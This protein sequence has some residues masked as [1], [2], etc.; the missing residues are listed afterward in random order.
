MTSKTQVLL[1]ALVRLSWPATASFGAD[2]EVEL[3]SGVVV[4]LESGGVRTFKGIPFAKPPVGDLRWRPPQEVDPW[5]PQKLS[6]RNFRHNCLQSSYTSYLRLPR[7]LSTLSEDCLYLNVYAPAVTGSGGGKTPVMFWLSGGGFMG[8]GGNE[9]RL[10]GTWDVA[11]SN[12]GLCVVTSNYRLG[13]FG[14][15]AAN[16]LRERDPDNG[17]GNYGI[18][19]QR[20]A[21][22]W[23]QEN[24]KHFGCDSERVFLVGQSAGALSVSQHL[25]RPKSWGLFA[26]AGM[27]SG[28]FYNGRDEPNV[29]RKRHTYTSLA[30]KVNC[31]P[32]DVDCL[33]GTPALALLQA[34]IDVDD[35]EPVVD[36]TDLTKPGVLLAMDGKLAPVPVLVG[37]VS[38]DGMPTGVQYPWCT[39]EECTE[40]DFKLWAA[41]F[42]DLD[43]VD[44][45]NLTAAYSEEVAFGNYTKW[46]WAAQHAG[47]DQW[48]NCFARRTASWVMQSGRNAYFYRWSYAPQRPNGEFPKLADH[49]CEVPFVFHVLSETPQQAAESGGVYHITSS[50]V[51]LSSAVVRYWRGMAAEGKPEGDVKWPAFN[52]HDRA[53]LEV[54]SSTGRMFDVKANLRGHQCDFWDR[55][56]SRGTRIRRRP[57]RVIF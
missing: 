50:E 14:F 18:L 32:K 28:A 11:L 46:Y 57:R 56:F 36:G 34:S 33:V 17:T 12:G 5:R 20:M 15:L 24:I 47:A 31:N 27:E 2:V 55:Y 43:Q 53:G 25:V 40:S 45:D 54:L 16:E 49:A 29:E 35:W 21:L 37:G 26:S 19:D 30:L 9:T 38:E 3:S 1:S 44:L 41:D 39:P 52:A 7:P 23:V 51:E 6:A 8:G 13:A 42:F 10:N 4:G 22:R 48:S